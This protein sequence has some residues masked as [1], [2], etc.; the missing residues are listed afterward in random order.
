MA[1][2]S[3]S[4]GTPIDALLQERARFQE[5]LAKLNSAAGGAPP[6]VR[7]KGRADYAGRLSAVMAQLRTHGAGI[8]QELD[9]HRAAQAEL[10]SRRSD[11]QEMLA[12][13]EIRYA[14]GEYTEEEWQRLS[15]DTARTLT[16]VQGELS[17]VVAEIE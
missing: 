7:D 11:A 9:R 16:D 15:D 17:R 13:A 10:E 5:W 12:E 2:S 6:G 14:V 8:Q 4:N 3:A 1:D